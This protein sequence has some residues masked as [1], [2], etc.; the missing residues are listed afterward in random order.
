MEGSNRD[1]VLYRGGSR[2]GGFEAG[3]GGAGRRV[4]RREEPLETLALPIVIVVVVVVVG[5]FALQALTLGRLAAPR[6]EVA[7][8][9]G[10]AARHLHSDDGELTRSA[11][12]E[13]S[14]F[15]EEVKSS[16]DEDIV[17]WKHWFNTEYGFF[18]AIRP[19][20]KKRSTWLHL[21]GK[22]WPKW[23]VVIF[24]GFYRILDSLRRDCLSLRMSTFS[25]NI[26]MNLL[27]KEFETTDRKRHPFPF[28]LLVTR[29]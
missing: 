5:R 16:F 9:E 23:H 26:L 3:T 29:A 22:W 14:T 12:G 28:V 27:V 17:D 7:S 25:L 20:V 2:G 11:N 19:L 13:T 8:G 1:D 18:T 21:A 15:D 4:V 6:L 10:S 24:N